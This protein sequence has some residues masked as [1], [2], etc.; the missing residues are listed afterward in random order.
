MNFY[1]DTDKTPFLPRSN[2]VDVLKGIDLPSQRG[3]N[4]AVNLMD[5]TEVKKYRW[6]V[7]EPYWYHPLFDEDWDPFPP[8]VGRILQ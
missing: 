1:D 4:C 5:D 7:P 6:P 8:H 2:I 3:F